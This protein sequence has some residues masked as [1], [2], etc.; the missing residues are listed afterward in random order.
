MHGL[1]RSL[2]FC[3]LAAASS[4]LGYVIPYTYSRELASRQT[5]DPKMVFAHLIVGITG[6]RASAADYDDDMKRAKALGIDAFA[7]NIGNEQPEVQL[8]FA[9][10]SAAANGM[11]AFISFDCNFFP[12]GQEGQIGALISQF[13]AKPAQLTVANGKPFVSTFIGDNLNVDAIRGA[14]GR[15]I[16]F[17]PNF[18]PGQGDFGKIDGA[19]NFQGWPS[20]G[21]NKAPSDGQLVTVNDGDQTFLSN[22]AGKSYMAPVSPW[23]STH[24]G[25]EVPF[26]KNWVFPSEL[27]IYQR[28]LEVLALK[29][30]FAEIVTW[31][32]YGE[33]HYIG[34]LS[35]KHTDDGASKW[36]NDMPHNGWADLSKPFIAAYKAGADKPDTFID[37]EK[38]IYWYRIT[39]KGLDCDATD[40]TMGAGNNATGDF[41]NGHPNGFDTLSDD[42]FVVSLLKTP[43]TVTV[44]SGGTLYTFDAP[45]GASAFQA[46]FKVG[47]Q[48]FALNR[49][50]AEVMSAV[51]LKA[52]Q[53]TCPCG[54]YNFNSYVG[55]VPEGPRDDLQA[56]G[57]TNFK[58]GLSSQVAC[59]AQPSLPATPPPTAAPTVT[60][61]VAAAPTSPPI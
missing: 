48:A 15:D 52:I 49:D 54:I 55:T 7:L 18:H 9:Y 60:S 2:L 59:D 58:N 29:P 41:F 28:W 36:A 53:D 57:L 11:K 5:S 14:A 22:L 19:F 56:D 23:F 1:V 61:S 37:E 46:P 13:A 34:P 21:R 50:G 39:P 3:S 4:S 24:F 26:S 12:P 31:N 10:D 44:N 47:T 6:N 45:A 51:S 16:F 25:G 42:V 38:I 32:D 40:T 30:S 43:G 20:N 33:S 27:L 8:G 17:V 35:S